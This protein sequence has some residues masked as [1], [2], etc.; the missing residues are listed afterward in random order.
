[1][2]KV[3]TKCRSCGRRVRLMNAQ[4]IA[5]VRLWGRPL[6]GGC[7]QLIRYEGKPGG[8]KHDDQNR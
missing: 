3:W 4:A 8:P 7:K 2:K 1:M 6:C 5:D